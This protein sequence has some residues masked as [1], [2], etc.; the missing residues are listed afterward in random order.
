MN[1]KQLEELNE[2]KL[3]Y[4]ELGLLPAIVQEASSGTILMMA[5]INE[6][7]FN[8]T[9]KSGL[10][11]FWSRSRNQLWKKGEISG[12]MMK[13]SEILVDC[14]QD[15]VIFIV[16]KTSGGA[17]HTSNKKGDFRNSCFYRKVDIQNKK[18]LFIEE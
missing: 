13:I 17:C 4:N 6:Q 11:T 10:A 1:K 3:Q 12:N 7:A 8:E 2:V 16:E 14:D 15:C 5:Y 9:L 18:L